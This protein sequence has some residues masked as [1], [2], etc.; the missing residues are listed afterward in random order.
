VEHLCLM[1]LVRARAERDAGDLRAARRAADEGVHT[2][3]QCGLGLY[4]VL[5]L[6]ARAEILLRAEPESAE[7]SA[8]EALALA[9]SPGCR[10]RWGESEAGHLLGQALAALWRFADARTVLSDTLALRHRI[11]D[12]GAEKTRGLLERL[13]S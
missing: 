3:A 6:N 2:A 8:R 5:M 4:H 13:P 11:G 1:H 10:F 7:R 9:A 12:P